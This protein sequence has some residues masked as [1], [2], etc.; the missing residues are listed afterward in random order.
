MRFE[1]LQNHIYKTQTTATLHNPYPTPPPAGT[2]AARHR[3]EAE[4]IGA[5]EEG[6]HLRGV[7][8]S[9]HP[10]SSRLQGSQRKEISRWRLS[11]Q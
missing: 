2:G 9:Y 1:S 7:L 5:A 6:R 10:Y 4:G 11:T 8:P 3:Q